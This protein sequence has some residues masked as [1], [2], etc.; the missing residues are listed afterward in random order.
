LSTT[1]PKA[2]AAKEPIQ[3]AATPPAPLNAVDKTIKAIDGGI[4]V[5]EKLGGFMGALGNLL[6][7]DDE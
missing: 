3:A 7:D 6:S 5:I 2:V 1:T 4:K